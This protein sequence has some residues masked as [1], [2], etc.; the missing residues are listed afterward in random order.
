MK[1]FRYRLCELILATTILAGFLA[2]PSPGQADDDAGGRLCPCFT[3]QMIDAA[4]V[5]LSGVP[6]LVE[7]ID[8]QDDG[9]SDT[10]LEIRAVRPDDNSN[11]MLGV[12]A[13]LENRIGQCDIGVFRIAG[14][15]AARDFDSQFDLFDD[16]APVRAY[17]ACRRE[18]RRSFA[19]RRFCASSKREH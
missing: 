5:T 16:E 13:S 11:D 12:G 7:C 19:W 15:D 3:S 1:R 10:Y 6:E 9:L 18:I 2:V 4:L 14:F 8:M 17:F